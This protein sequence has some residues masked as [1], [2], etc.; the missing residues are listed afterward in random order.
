MLIA[1][2]FTFNKELNACLQYKNVYDSSTKERRMYISDMLKEE[3][4]LMYN[5]ECFNIWFESHGA[6]RAEEECITFSEFIDK[7]S[8][9]FN[10]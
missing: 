8:E 6:E 4:I 7:Y 10:K 1:Q 3:T 2:E 5:S 9:L